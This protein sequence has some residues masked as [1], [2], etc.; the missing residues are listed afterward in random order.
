MT[1]LESITR[2]KNAFL[3]KVL[4]RFPYSKVRVW[5]FRRLGHKCGENVYFPS[6]VVISQVFVRSRSCLT[7]GNR[8]SIG[9]RVTFILDSAPNF[10]QIRSLL[11]PKVP[12]IIVEDDAWIGANSVILSGVRI[13]RDA[14]IGA[15]SVVTKDVEPFTIV[16]GNP[17]RVIK[18]L[19]MGSNE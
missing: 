7:L 19:P 5:A 9:P 10:S 17:A 13:G 2:A 1:L 8:V 18:R 15:G 16:A 11:T 14:V 4:L 6:D 3:Y 12:E